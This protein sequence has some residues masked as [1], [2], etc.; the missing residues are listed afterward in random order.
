MKSQGEFYINNNNNFTL[1]SIQLLFKM[2]L[3]LYLLSYNKLVVLTASPAWEL[4]SQSFSQTGSFCVII[5]I[6]ID[7]YNKF[8]L[9]NYLPYK[10]ESI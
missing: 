4:V 5:C 10:I 3:D 7:S 2:L 6:D 1:S 9:P 8:V